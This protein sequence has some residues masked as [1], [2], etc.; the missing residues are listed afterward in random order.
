MGIR[1]SSGS[2]VA[3][4]DAASQRQA[5]N[6]FRKARVL[7]QKIVAR[8]PVLSGAL[9][10]SWNASYGTADYSFRDVKGKKTG[11]VTIGP[12]AFGLAY[13]RKQAWHIFIANGAPYAQ[14]VEDGWSDRA[15]QGMV[16][17]SIREVFGG[18]S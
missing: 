5:Y 4:V 1:R 9:R 8:T 16:R 7:Y 12:K 15:P 6:N 2:L 13:D 11:T 3:I 10:A 14:R 17:I 18:S